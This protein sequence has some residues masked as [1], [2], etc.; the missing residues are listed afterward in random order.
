MAKPRFTDY[1]ELIH[2]LFDRFTQA[3]TTKPKRGSPFDF[4]D[5]SFVIFFVWMQM[6]HTTEFRAQHRWLENH[7]EHANA[8]YLSVMPHRTTISRRYKA[9]YHTLQDFI[10]F[11]GTFAQ[12]LELDFRSK[13]LFEDKSLF[14]AKGLSGIRR[15]AKEITSRTSYA[16]LIKTH[17]VKVRITAGSMA[18]ACMSPAQKM[19]FQGRVQGGNRISV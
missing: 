19:A 18:M 17:G 13:E 7:A 1:V 3:Q 9:L 15:I 11:V 4:K 14:K 16:T 6:R 8:Y 5:K 12:D 2:T 10:A